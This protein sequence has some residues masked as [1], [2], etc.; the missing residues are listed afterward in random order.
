MKHLKR[1]FEDKETN[2]FKNDNDEILLFFTDYYDAGNFQ[3]KDVMVHDDGTS[4]RIISETSYMRNPSEYRRAKLIKITIPTDNKIYFQNSGPT[5]NSTNVL[6]DLLHDIKRFYA[7]TGEEINFQFENSYVGLKVNILTM[8]PS[9]DEG[10][11]Q[12]KEIDELIKELN[13]IFRENQFRPRIS[14]PSLELKTSAKRSLSRYGDYSIE[15]R[16]LLTRILSG[17][18]NGGTKLTDKLVS[19]VNKVT[20]S[21]FNLDITGG[22]HQVIIKIKKQ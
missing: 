12:I 5:F 13:I 16:R 4:K 15:L 2:D 6:D 22:D 10:D 7:M 20:E 3:I 18:I 11:S 19:W 8:G 1:I 9:F 21:G 17:E 14:G